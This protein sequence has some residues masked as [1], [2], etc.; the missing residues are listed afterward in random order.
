MLVVC[1]SW[2]D[3]LASEWD[4]GRE[5]TLCS[6]HSTKP[7]VRREGAGCVSNATDSL[8]LVSFMRFS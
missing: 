5:G 4:L 7:G 1:P 6:F 3:A 2:E 8:F